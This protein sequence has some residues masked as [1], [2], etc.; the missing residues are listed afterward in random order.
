[1]IVDTS[2]IVAILRREPGHEALARAILADPSPKMSAATAVELYAVA[3]VRGAPAEAA[4]VDAALATLRIE[5]VAF[6]ERQAAIARRAYHDFGKGSRSRARLNLGDTFSYALAARVAEPLLYVGDDFTHTDMTASSLLATPDRRVAGLGAETAPGSPQTCNSA[7]DLGPQIVES[8]V[9]GRKTVPG[10]P[11]P[12]TRRRT[13]VGL[14][15]SWRLEAR[16]ERC[17]GAVHCGGRAVFLA[18]IRVRL[19]RS[20]CA[21]RS[22]EDVRGVPG[23]LPPV[24]ACAGCPR[25]WCPWGGGGRWRG[26]ASGARRLGACGTRLPRHRV[27]TG[28]LSARFALGRG[29]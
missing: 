12:A 9:W 23:A 27:A 18:P 22:S 25:P 13:C 6:D 16:W 29:P 15:A 3:D 17:R 2:A 14:P 11:K 4:R 19:G 8:Q 26:P 28:S 24:R 20:R 21:L 1:M 10:A 7:E 5:I